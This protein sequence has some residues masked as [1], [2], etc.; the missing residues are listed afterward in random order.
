MFKKIFAFILSL[1]FLSSLVGCS[2]LTKKHQQAQETPAEESARNA[3]VSAAP[4]QAVPFLLQVP[5]KSFEQNLKISGKVSAGYK[6]FIN[7]AE[8]SADPQG[9]FNAEIKLNPGANILEFKTVSPDGTSVYT[10]SRTIEYDQKPKL[11][12]KQPGEISDTMITVEGTTEPDCVVDVNGYKTRSDAN[13]SFKISIP[14][15]DGNSIIEI[16]ST[17]KAGKSAVVQKTMTRNGF[18]ESL[19]Q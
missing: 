11:E 9:S 1:I 14:A 4:Q 15:A 16:V 19:V 3:D 6:V 12:I 8:F 2:K 10:T 18:Q 7:G 13:G 17:N 5:E